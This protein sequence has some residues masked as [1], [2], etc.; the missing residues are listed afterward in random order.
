MERVVLLVDDELKQEQYNVEAQIEL[1]LQT[2]IVL[3]QNQQQVK[4]VIHKLVVLLVLLQTVYV[5]K[6]KQIL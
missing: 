6:Q 5:L 1:Q 4:L 2:V 3:E